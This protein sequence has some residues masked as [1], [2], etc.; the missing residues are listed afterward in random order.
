M[1][2]DQLKNITAHSVDIAEHLPFLS[3][4]SQ[5][6][7][8]ITEMGVRCCVSTW[9]FIDGLQRQG[10]T[11]VSIDIV[12]PP[13]ENLAKVEEVCKDVGV[14]FT[15]KLAD[16]LKLKIDE[17]DLL[18]ID[19]LHTK[20]QLTKELELHADKARKYIVLHDTESCR[21][22][23]WG[24]IMNL[25]NQGKWEIALHFANNNGLTILQRC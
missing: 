23:L 9:A 20:E 16:T 25:V 8:H 12:Y 4:L 2:V 11:L 5:E 17:T 24:P 14:D 19:T 22:E 15:F 10:G 6:C 3:E 18:F 1:A 7:K 13:E 21:D